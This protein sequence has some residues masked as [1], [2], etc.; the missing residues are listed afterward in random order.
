MEKILL[1][2]TWTNY[3]IIILILYLY[4]KF[5][6][7]PFW[8]WFFFCFS[9][10]VYIIY[11]YMSEV[12]SVVV[13]Q[14]YG[15]CWCFKF[16]SSLLLWKLRNSTFYFFFSVYFTHSTISFVFDFDCRM[17]YWYLVVFDF[18][19]YLFILLL[20]GKYMIQ[21]YWTSFKLLWHMIGEGFSI[22]A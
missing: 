14:R 22:D 12:G 4:I 11:E 2:W 5:I 19:T 21:S 7:F 1:Q 9:K 18:S 17:E 13:K 3:E 15:W 20:Y 10:N 8:F 16:T 6:P